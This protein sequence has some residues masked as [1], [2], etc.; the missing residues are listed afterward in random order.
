MNVRCPNC[1]A[2]FP[3]AGGGKQVECPLCLLRFEAKDEKTESMP[4]TPKGARGASSPSPEDEFESFGTPVQSTGPTQ[5]VV[6]GRGFAGARTTGP[7]PTAGVGLGSATRSTIP[8]SAGSVAPVLGAM[9]S[10]PSLGRG[11]GPVGASSPN[12]PKTAPV[13]PPAMTEP[14]NARHNASD[15][16]QLDLNADSEI[17]FDAL[18]SDAVDAVEK[19]NGPA[20][21]SRSS[22][23]IRVAAPRSGATVAEESV[24]AAPLLSRPSA[25]VP[26]ATPADAKA[27]GRPSASADDSLFESGPTEAAVVEREAPAKAAAPAQRRMQPRA[28]QRP[29]KPLGPAV[30]RA[31]GTL[32]LVAGIAG[33]AGYLLGYGWFFSKFWIKQPPKVQLA[34]AMDPALLLPVALFD[35][36]KSYLAEAQRLERVV[37]LHPTDKVAKQ[38]LL[39]RYLDLLERAPHV[40][41]ESGPYRKRLDVLAKA[42][43]SPPRLAVLDSMHQGLQTTPAQMTSLLAGSVDDR[44]VA[45]RNAVAL[46]EQRQIEVALAR[47]GL[48]AA[49]DVDPLRALVAGDPDL[50]KARE[51]MDKLLPETAA[52]PQFAK[53]KALDAL[54]RD[55]LHQYEGTVAAMEAIATHADDHIEA[56]MLLASAH[57]EAG[58]LDQATA[59]ADEAARLATDQQVPALAHESRQIEARIAQKRGD[60]E[61]MIKSL[62]ASLQAVAGDELGTVRLARLLNAEKHAQDA[63]KLLVGA[64][65]S[66]MKSIAFEVAFVEFWLGA[67]RLQDALEETNQATKLYP[68]SVD[69]LFL[70]GQVEDKA[71][72]VATARD[73]FEQVV[74]KEPRHLRAIVRLAELLSAADKHDESL[75]VL[76]NARKTVS[77]DETVLRLMVEELLAVKRDADARHLLDILLKTSPQNRSYLLRAAQLDLKQGEVERALGFLRRLRS[78]KALDRQA[79]VQMAE[80]LAKKQQMDE[81]AQTL[82]PFAEAAPADVDL[83]TLAG[84]YLVDAKDFDHAKTLLQRATQTANGKSPEALFQYGR[85]A[86]RQ[87]DVDQALVR[88]QH[89]IEGDKSAWQYRLEMAKLLF[90]LKGRDGARDRAIEQLMVIL[91][92][93]ASYASAGHP[94]TEVAEVHRLLAR[95]YVE[96][97]RYKQAIPH[98]QAVVEADPDDGEALQKLG[99]AMYSVNDPTA[100]KVLAKVL[101]RHPGDAKA[102]FL[103]G[104][105]ALNRHQSSEALHFLELAGNSGKADVAEAWYHVAL[106]YKDRGEPTAALRSVENYQKQ[107]RP[108]DI[109]QSDVRILKD[110]LLGS[111]RKGSKGH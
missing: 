85:L 103:L 23:F 30:R 76:E 89:A 18:L 107:A 1:S 96:L 53:F 29:S 38:A 40:M 26:V 91:S 65:K 33:A 80:A 20:A 108:A 111:S 105:S 74:A 62:Q 93:Q 88:F 78:N 48:T 109:Y 70:R 31:V 97:H 100:G 10:A 79:A 11:T 95:Q 36:A 19:R 104:M 9:S 99:D 54:V 98:L 14:E 8:L 28:G 49:A 59:L 16:G 12:D 66:G 90:D 73:L 37:A 17:D 51:W 22:P 43:G 56:R 46:S 63:Q 110:E 84:K 75:Q 57:L 77:D 42:V 21:P 69:L 4:Q 106:I 32:L 7:V 47:P 24:L 13:R 72:H 81:A 25:V 5:T 68:N 35:S 71:Q 34:K 94:V 52:L 67:N 45:V 6:Q 58:E 64:K 101:Q 86:F 3:S 102:A 2:V 44:G 39:D 15:M 55:R 92:G 27:G 82:L 83:N 61:A 41:A 60:R 50:K 87:G